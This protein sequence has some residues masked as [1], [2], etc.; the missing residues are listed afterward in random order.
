MMSVFSQLSI[1]IGW[2][3]KETIPALEVAK[4]LCELVKNGNEEAFEKVFRV[5]RFA[6][7]PANL[8]EIA[9]NA[10]I[11]EAFTEGRRIFLKE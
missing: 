3:G 11:C 4:E 9:A 5:Y 6:P 7:S 1:K 10:V 8:D 2:E